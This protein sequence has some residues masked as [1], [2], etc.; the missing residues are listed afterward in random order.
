MR[1][2][3][4]VKKMIDLNQFESD[5]LL[6][7][8]HSFGEDLALIPLLFLNDQKIIRSRINDKTDLFYEVSDLSYPPAHCVTRTDRASLKGHPMF[9]ASV[10][11]KDAEKTGALPRIISAMETLDILKESHTYQQ[12]I[13]TQSAWRVKEDIHLF[14][15]PVSDKY[16]RA[17]SELNMFRKDWETYCKH[18]YSK[19]SIE[20]FSFIGDLMATT[21]SSCIYEVTATCVDYIIRNFDFE[22]VV[23]PSVPSEGEGLNICIT[24]EVVNIKVAFEGAVAETV[25]RNNM[26]TRIE[27]F[28]H[29][30]MVSPTSFNWKVTEYG[31]KLMEITGRYPHFKENEEVIL[32]P[33]YRIKK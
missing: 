23:Y 25:I 33:E 20:F 11:T 21:A 31:R 17:C 18:N 19:N 8:L 9:Y 7:I 1:E 30:Q 10:F 12:C 29:A 28:A 2:I 27:S 16:K 22:G 26:E 24:P 15:F 14:A 4:F 32:A 3:E 13:F 5:M 6:S